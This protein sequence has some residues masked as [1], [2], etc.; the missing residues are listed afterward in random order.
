[1]RFATNPH[2]PEDACY[3]SSLPLTPYCFSRYSRNQEVSVCR[4]RAHNTVWRV[5][6]GTGNREARQGEIVKAGD[7]ILLEHVQT[8]QYLANDKINYQTIFGVELE[9][10]CMT[11][12][13]PK[14]TQILLQEAQG[15]LVR[16]N[17]HKAVFEANSWS[18]CL[19]SCEAE[20]QSAPITRKTTPEDILGLI[21]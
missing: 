1:M 16:E 17:T 9:V 20:T 18:F 8:A 6:P 12:G 15:S 11:L 10:S 7:P 5:Q 14:R 3:L 4:R 21:K 19:A 13:I 2:Q